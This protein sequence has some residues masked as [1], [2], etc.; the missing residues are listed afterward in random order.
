MTGSFFL[1][2]SA[3]WRREMVRFLR[4]RSR[5]VGAF[6]SPLIFWLLLGFGVGQSFNPVS[7]A[8]AMSYQEY[9]FP[10]TVLMILLF[11]SIFSTI[12]I[13]ED[14]KEGFLQAVLVAPVPRSALVFGKLLGGTSLAM[15]QGVLF[16]LLAPLAGVPITRIPAALAT[17]A[18]V[19]FGLTALGYV[20]AWKM[21]STQGFHAIMNLFL[22]PMWLL[23]GAVFPASGAPGWLRAV[24]GVNPLTYG[25]SAVRW[26]IYGSDVAST[27]GLPGF[28]LSIG[29]T[30]A[31]AAVV[32]AAA[33]TMTR[34]PA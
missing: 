12:S 11:T 22:I 19:S 33:I 13:I 4:Q 20:I 27:M 3:L 25:M 15:M 32:F 34:R 8:R 28:V 5:I 14:R 2:A 24:I 21:D 7:Q 23:S 18:L 26:S 31:F 6:A 29:V 17:L 16:M 1:S 9:F 10:G 30:V